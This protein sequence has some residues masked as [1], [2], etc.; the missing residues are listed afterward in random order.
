MPPDHFLLVLMTAI[1][2]LEYAPHCEPDAYDGPQRTSGRP[3]C[4]ISGI[5][6]RKFVST[7]R[8]SGSENSCGTRKASAKAR[9]LNSMTTQAIHEPQKLKLNSV[10]IKFIL[11]NMPRPSTE[12]FIDLRV[13][14]NT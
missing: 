9:E 13:F 6:D 5:L 8:R 2:C 1:A 7:F 12:L 14:M 4:A 11:R 3:N 10:R